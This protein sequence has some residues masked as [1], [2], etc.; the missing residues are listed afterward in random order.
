MTLSKR[1][2][3]DL[4]RFQAEQITALRNQNEYLKNELKQ[5][6]EILQSLINEWEVEAETL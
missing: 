6:K 5:A 4:E 2:S 1:E 3:T